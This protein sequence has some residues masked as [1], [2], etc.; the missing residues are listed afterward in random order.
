[1]STVHVNVA[2]LARRAPDARRVCLRACVCLCACPALSELQARLQRSA[3]ETARLQQVVDKSKK[4]RETELLMQ[5]NATLEKK[6]ISQEDEF[7]LQNQTLL[8]ELSVVSL[9]NGR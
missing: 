2:L 1:M 8:Q 3:G 7:R 4:A 6:L 5:T 9:S